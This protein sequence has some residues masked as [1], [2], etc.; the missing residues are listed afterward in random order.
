MSAEPQPAPQL[1]PPEAA[2]LYA[3]LGDST[4]LA[5]L[6]RLGD[7]MSR[8]VSDLANGMDITRQAVTK[9][10]R[11]LEAAD[12]VASRRAGRHTMFVLHPAGLQTARDHLARASAQWDDALAR[13]MALV[14]QP[15]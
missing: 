14:D 8:S 12:M 9:H 11:I 13:L 5:L 4:R 6:G 7:G 2:P 10:L 1:I 3:A 15:Q